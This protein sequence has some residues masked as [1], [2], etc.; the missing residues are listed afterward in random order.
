MA[1]HNRQRRSRRGAWRRSPAVAAAVLLSLALAGPGQAQVRSRF[2][3]AALLNPETS[4]AFSPDGS[5][6]IAAGM[7]LANG[8]SP[9]GVMVWDTA[10]GKL[11]WKRP[12]CRA[13]GPSQPPPPFSP[14][15][16]LVAVPVPDLNGGDASIELIG[17]RKGVSAVSM[18]GYGASPMFCQ[19]FTPDGKTLV[20]ASIDP[21]SGEE[22]IRLE[23]VATGA[24]RKSIPAG[25]DRLISQIA[26]APDGRTLATL[27]N[28]KLQ[29]FPAI[30]GK[31]RP[32]VGASMGGGVEDVEIRLWDLP[33]GTK[34]ASLKAT[35]LY[36][37]LS[38][39]RF[40]PDGD[41]VTLGPRGVAVWDTAAEKLRRTI[42]P[43]GTGA[44]P[45][46]GLLGL[47]SF[48]FLTGEHQVVVGLANPPTIS[49]CD[50]KTGKSRR[51]LAAGWNQQ[52][53]VMA[54]SPRGHFAATTAGGGAALW[55]TRRGN[56]LARLPGLGP[57]APSP[58]AV[59]GP[60]VF[61]PDETALAGIG[62]DGTAIVW[63]LKRWLP[64]GKPKP[65]AAEEDLGV[66][67][68]RPGPAGKGKPAAKPGA[69][70]KP[71]PA[72]KPALPPQ[73][74]TWTSADGRFTVAAEFV[75]AIGGRVTLR[76]R[77]GTE[78]TVSIAN[79]SQA[80]RRLLA[81]KAAGRGD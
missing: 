64:K 5:L 62:F 65:Q 36:Q 4:A 59:Y 16:K 42:P 45:A 33:E 26:V 46:S 52:A 67:T 21:Q 8:P 39:I 40:A 61:A 49:L 77:D 29:Q 80:D 11:L 79:L 30:G 9:H 55:D 38:P 44:P 78:I 24:R 70:T 13:M 19:A 1:P 12:T 14:D 48:G 27:H 56:L 81:N 66:N 74:R 76:K 28:G 69:K 6:L 34:R 2:R 53:L 73:F 23:D 17:S 71:A 15:G 18:R 72:A 68:P 35:G 47:T 7:G 57:V 32:G 54:I 43:A 20:T 58:S 51:T 25:K 50:L 31:G 60:L 75:K 3:V 63:D 41:L 37:A 22:V 10:S